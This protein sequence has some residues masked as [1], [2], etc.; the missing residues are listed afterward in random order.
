[1]L[2]NLIA[3]LLL[4]TGL[5]S[6]RA[7]AACLVEA[8]ATVPLTVAGNVI[9][10][11]VEVNG[12]QA[13][14][15]LDTG[16]ERSMVTTEAVER[17]KLARDPWVGTAMRGV[18]GIS[19][20][21][22]A[23]PRSLSLGGVKL[24]RRTLNHDTSLTVGVLRYTRA[25]NKVIDGLLGID[26]LSVFDLDLDMPNARLTIFQVQ[27]CA[28]RFLPWTEAY[29]SVPVTIIPIRY[30]LILPV[31]LDGIP[32]Q[33]FLDSGASSGLVFRSGMFRMGLQESNLATDPADEINGVGP[34]TVV[35][36]RHRF[37]SLR[38]GHQTIN[39][40]AIWVA[41]IQMWPNADMLLGA[42]WLSGQR[43]WISYATQQIFVA[44]K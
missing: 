39:A 25:G 6:V 22:N 7:E 41:P 19:Q 15:I 23:N 28:G 11:P 44:D 27:D 30:V 33:A 26:F 35:M 2:R 34:R 31:T 43:T 13:T 3:A 36:H 5:L 24:A 38:I 42:D 9:I 12:I 32:L 40:P 14:F 37:R 8:K 1:M 17:L 20:R 4:L 10:L 29:T 18:G 16:A 21:Y